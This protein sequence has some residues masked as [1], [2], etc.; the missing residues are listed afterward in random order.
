MIASTLGLDPDGACKC[1]LHVLQIALAA[2]ESRTYALELPEAELLNS[3]QNS[4][5]VAIVLFSV[6]PPES[7]FQVG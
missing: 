1:P 4:P 6:L 3:L 7:T 5:H 2:S